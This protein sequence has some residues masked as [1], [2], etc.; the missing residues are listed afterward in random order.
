M[1]QEFHVLIV[2]EARMTGERVS[3]HN[4]KR[5]RLFSNIHNLFAKYEPLIRELCTN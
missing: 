2:T 5:N 3:L 1:K 4:S